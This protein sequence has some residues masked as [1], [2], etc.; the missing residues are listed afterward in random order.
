MLEIEIINQD[1][2]FDVVSLEYWYVS[3]EIQSPSFAKKKKL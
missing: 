2:S 3:W 1:H